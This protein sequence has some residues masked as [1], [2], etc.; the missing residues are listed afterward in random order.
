M[1]M[2][3]ISRQQFLVYILKISLQISSMTETSKMLRWQK[4]VLKRDFTE[5]TGDTVTIDEIERWENYW[6]PLEE[7]EG[8]DWIKICKNLRR[9]IYEIKE[10]GSSKDGFDKEWAK[11]WVQKNF[12][13]PNLHKD[14]NPYLV[15]L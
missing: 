15:T 9:I 5:V 7:E 13:N 6:K 14:V 4:E 3:N 8:K 11:R 2:F 10:S 12:H 1:Q